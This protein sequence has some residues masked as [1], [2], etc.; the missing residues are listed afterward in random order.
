[1]AESGFTAGLGSHP[2]S[3]DAGCPSTTSRNS[4]G[5]VDG[6]RNRID[7]LRN[8]TDGLRNPTDGPSSLIVG[9]RNPADGLPNLI[10]D[11]RSLN[12]AP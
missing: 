5:P 11:L 2:V 9:R 4:N 3:A 12:V 6:H 10:V 1:M 7:G 8:P